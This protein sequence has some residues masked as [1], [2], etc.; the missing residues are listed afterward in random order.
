M[1]SW[2]TFP[3]CSRQAARG[4]SICETSLLE[5]GSARVNPN[6]TFCVFGLNQIIVLDHP[7]K[8]VN[9]SNN[10]QSYTNLTKICDL[11]PQTIVYYIYT[12]LL[13]LISMLWHRQIEIQIERRQVV[14][15]CWMQDLNPWS[16]TSNCHQTECPLTNWLSYRGSSKTWTGQPVP[17]VTI[18]LDN[19]EN[20]S[21]GWLLRKPTVR[22][23]C[24]HK[25]QYGTVCQWSP[26]CGT[27]CVVIPMCVCIT[28]VTSYVQPI[29]SVLHHSGL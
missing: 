17:I 3:A 5:L 14:F 4:I 2:H 13:L 25:N 9:I 8:V 27:V 16:Q 6:T 12:C 11:C 21:S 26:I 18:R 19:A 10:T 23:K 29:C 15:L 20:Q 1:H 24:W 28:P 7:T 22:A